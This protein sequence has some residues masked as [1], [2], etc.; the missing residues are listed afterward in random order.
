MNSTTASKLAL[1]VTGSPVLSSLLT[2]TVLVAGLLASSVA[3]V[4][5]SGVMAFGRPL[6]YCALF[7]AEPKAEKAKAI[8]LDRLSL[9]RS[10]LLGAR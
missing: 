4:M 5:L 10:L 8:D 6:L 3:L 9:H 2:A 7:N 1:Y